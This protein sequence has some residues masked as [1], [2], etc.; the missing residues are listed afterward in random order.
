MT[1]PLIGNYGRLVED[2]QSERPWLRGL[3]VAHATAAVWGAPADRPPAA[4]DAASQPSQV[5]IPAP[6][7]ATFARP[8]HSG[9]LSA[10]GAI[11][12]EAAVAA[13]RGLTALGGSGL[14]RPGLAR[15]R[16][17]SG[18]ARR[19]AGRGRRLRPQD[20]HRARLRREASVRVLPHTA[21]ARRLWRRRS[22]ASSSRRVP[23]IRRDSTVR[24]RWRGPSSR[25]AGRCWASASATRSSAAPP[26]P[27]R[28]RLRFGHHGANHPVQDLETGKSRSRPRTTRSR[29]S[30]RRFPRRRL[31]RQPANLNDG[32]V[33]GL[34]HARAA[35]RDRAVPPRGLARARSTRSPSSTG[36]SRLLGSTA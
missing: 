12:V 6:W 29:S 9:R 8:E 19:A 5:S 35:D 13:A 18:R 24:S 32:S 20:Q 17:T 2:D 1:Y 36:S 31:L 27:T 26:A 3:I 14:R 30:A 28:R 33:E 15:R 7:R 22:P 23:A 25:T 16:T 34:R 21:T 11:D 4:G 10:P